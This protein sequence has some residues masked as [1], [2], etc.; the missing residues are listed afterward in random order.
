VKAKF[1]LQQALWLLEDIH[2]ISVA[3]KSYNKA[4]RISKM[5][6]ARAFIAL[7]AFYLGEKNARELVKP[8]DSLYLLNIYMQICVNQRDGE[9]AIRAYDIYEDIYQYDASTWYIV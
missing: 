3:N 7:R 8:I 4:M 5:L 9:E 6:D 2:N 1:L